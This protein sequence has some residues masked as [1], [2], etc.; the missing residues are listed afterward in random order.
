MGTLW[1]P[2]VKIICSFILKVKVLLNSP[3]AIKQRGL[4]K[5]KINIAAILGWGELV[6]ILEYFP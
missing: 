3:D 5:R 1:V 4:K 2:G 6:F